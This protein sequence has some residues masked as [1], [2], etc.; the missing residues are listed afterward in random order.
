M[1]DPDSPLGMMLSSI[2]LVLVFAMALEGLLL[3]LVMML[4]LVVWRL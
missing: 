3:C 4:C 1:I 2:T